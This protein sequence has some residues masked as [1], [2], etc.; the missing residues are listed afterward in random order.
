MTS[1][2]LI[3]VSKL[4]KHFGNFVAV[5]GIDLNVSA[6][7]VFGLLGANGAGKTTAIRMLCGMLAPSGGTMEV[8]GVDMVRQPRRARGRIGYVS[9]GFTL[10]GDLSLRENLSLQAGL[11]GLDRSEARQ[12]IEWALEYLEL[13]VQAEEMARELPLG[14]LRRLSLAAALLHKPQVLFLDEPTSGVDPLARQHFWELIYDLAESGIAILVTTH[15][16]DEAAFCDRLALMH[17]GR[18]VDEGSPEALLAKPLTTALV[19]LRAS[20]CNDC[21]PW[22]TQQPEVSEVIPHAGL[23]RIT[24]RPDVEPTPFIDRMRSAAQQHDVE[25]VTLQVVAPTLEDLFVSVLEK[26]GGAQ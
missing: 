2:S 7:E 15:Y 9:Q 17:S 3:N 14:Y 8:A 20:R 11:Y 25:N 5:D 24:L 10:Y 16:M 13:S 1:T 18:I 23:L 4:S 6:G 21:I 19:E 22:L 26:A 12:R